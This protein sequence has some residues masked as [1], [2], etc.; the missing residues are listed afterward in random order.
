MQSPGNY[1]QKAVH[2]TGHKGS[3][4]SLPR[5]AT[6]PHLTIPEPEV[7]IHLRN[8]GMLAQ[9]ITSFTPAT[10]KALQRPEK[11]PIPKKPIV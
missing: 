9:P 5:R 8:T 3:R 1:F 11:V 4:V 7:P 6:L 2:H 10:C